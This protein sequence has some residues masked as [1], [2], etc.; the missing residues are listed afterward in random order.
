MYAHSL[1]YIQKKIKDS[2]LSFEHFISHFE[3]LSCYRLLVCFCNNLGVDV[4]S[5]M[6]INT[7]MGCV[8]AGMW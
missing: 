8:G 7:I 2:E 4:V 5:R 1:N 3:L 6:L